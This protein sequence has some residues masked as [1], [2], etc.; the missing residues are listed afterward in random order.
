LIDE[1]GIVP[2]INE[3]LGEHQAE[4]IS[5]GQVVKGMILNGL[6]LVSSPLYLFSRFFEGKATEHLLGEGI[7]AEYLNDE[8]LGRVLDSLY[9]TGLNQIFVSIAL[10]VVKKYQI[11][12][13]TVHLDS[14]SFSV[15]GESETESSELEEEQQPRAV[16]ITHGYSRDHRPDL[17]QFMM[18]LICSADGDVPL[19]MRIGDGNESDRQ[20]FAQIMREFK[21]QLKWD[22]LIVLDS[23]FYSQENLQSSQSI[24]WLSRVPLTV[25][26]AGELV[27][28]VSDEALMPSQLTGYRYQEIQK[29]Y[30]GINQRWLVVESQK[31]RESDLNKFAKN[32]QKEAVEAAK[33]LLQLSRQ[34][35]ACI[36]DAQQ[37]AQKLLKK[38]KY[39]QITK[40]KVETVTQKKGKPSTTEAYQVRGTVSLSEEKVEPIR[41][42]AGR[43]ILATNVL[44]NDVLTA[45]EVLSKYKDQ[46]VVERG[47]RFL[48]DPMFFTDSVF[49]K[50]PE[51]IEALGLIMGLC[52]L[53]YTLGQRQLRQTLQRCQVKVPNQ[54][55][56]RTDRPTL[57]WIF[58]CFQSIHVLFVRQT[59]EISNLTDERLSLLKFFPSACQR[60]Y[61]PSRSLF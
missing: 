30:G 41:S 7:K 39:H 58:H 18:D 35:F 34:Q 40:I 42:C 61:L 5:A 16:K 48:K 2:K 29:T 14:S 24:W 23:A 6:G 17:K 21:S 59:V 51:R 15:Q 49:L 50:S 26:A 12:V 47:F 45:E 37:A 56:R 43:F 52:L 53:V 9:Q 19:W 57:G 3:L 60:Y 54:L 31:R 36:P 32:V 38:S 10:E 22:S 4:K 25:K 44:D 20:Q 46:Q 55:G 27:R 13:E 11:K 8:R 33:Q 28:D 1:I